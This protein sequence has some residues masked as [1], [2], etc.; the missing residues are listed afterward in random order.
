MKTLVLRNKPLSAENYLANCN[1]ARNVRANRRVDACHAI[2]KGI[3]V[4]IASVLVCVA[5]GGLIQIAIL[6]SA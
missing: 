2:Y 1:H 5:V 3:V 4:T 6:L